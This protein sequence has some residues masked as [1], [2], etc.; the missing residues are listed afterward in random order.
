MKKQLVGVDNLDAHICKSSGKFYADSTIILTP[1]AKDELNKRKICIVYGE[2]PEPIQTMVCK[3]TIHDPN[4]GV[5]SLGWT[6]TTTSETVDP[7]TAAI[8]ELLISVA[9]T[10]KTQYNITDPEEL[11]K[12]SIQVVKTLKDNL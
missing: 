4:C 5:C 1:G 3:P 7:K 11:K 6:C 8:E 2:K 9:A 12:I 10:L